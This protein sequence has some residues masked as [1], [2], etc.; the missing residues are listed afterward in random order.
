MEMDARFGVFLPMGTAHLIGVEAYKKLLCDNNEYQQ[1]ITT[2]PMGNFQHD[3]LHLPFPCDHNTDIDL[4]NLYE[5]ILDQPWC[6]SVEKMTMPNK[7]LIV[8][9][10]GQVT[11]A[12]NWAEDKL[13][14][15][16]K[17]NI[18]DKL[19]VTTLQQLIPHRLDKLHV[20][21]AAT[22]Y[23]D[24]LN[25]RSSYILSTATA[26]LQ[27]T[28]PTKTHNIKPTDLTYAAVASRTNATTR[29]TMST[30]N[31]ESTTQAPPPSVAAHHST[32]MLNCSVSPMK[33]KQN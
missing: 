21:T 2:V 31:A 28:H 19:D 10:K 23:M 14:E 4:T 7:I 17:Q 30:T 22:R 8:T 3:T 24:K 29:T 18:A 5:I 27:F 16:Y 1:S 9:T 15:L 33:L 6:L 25:Q 13:P 11:A 32:I 26:S 12:R 20:T